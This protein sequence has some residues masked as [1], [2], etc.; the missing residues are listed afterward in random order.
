MRTTLHRLRGTFPYLVL[1]RMGFTLPPVFAGAVR[2][3]R[4]ISPLPRVAAWRYIFCGTFRGLTPPRRYLASCP[5]EP[6]L[7]SIA[8]QRPVRADASD[9]D[10]PA[11]LLGAVWEFE[12]TNSI[13]QASS[14]AETRSEAW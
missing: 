6:G 4:T 10:H 9:S 12:P 1:L 14:A 7:S 13:A 8:P 3:Y 5:A 2:S 11:D